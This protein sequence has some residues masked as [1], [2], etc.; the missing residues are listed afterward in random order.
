MC[1]D[2]YHTPKPLCSRLFDKHVRNILSDPDQV[3]VDDTV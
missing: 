1:F 2:E 3:V